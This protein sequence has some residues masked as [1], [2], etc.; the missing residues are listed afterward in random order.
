MTAHTAGSVHAVWSPAAL[1]ADVGQPIVVLVHGAMDR[2]AS[3]G[4]AVRLLGDVPVVRYDRRGYGHSTE[5][6]VGDLDAHVR[7]LR[8]LIAGRPSVLVGH[9]IGGVIA[10]VAA[11]GDPSVLSVAAW[12]ASMAWAPWWPS[13]SAG[14]SVL[15][16]TAGNGTGENGMDD[17]EA[18]DAAERFM[19]K[20]IGV[21]RWSRLPTSTRV[22]RRAEG[23]ALIA[24]IAALHRN[25]A[26]YDVAALTQ[27][28]LAGY[29]TGSR[30]YHQQAARELA[31]TVADAELMVVQGADHGAHLSHATEFATFVRRAV[32]RAATIPGTTIPGTTLRP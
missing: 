12:E 7:D 22:A 31:T 23:R 27:P 30:P 25:A 2:S 13:S 15:A 28:V 16:S 26:P 8:G 1:A 18:G 17:E 10:L 24:D 29:G 5:L 21:E 11:E 4:R 32:A 20:M 9:S 19:C 14:S 3:F 6:G